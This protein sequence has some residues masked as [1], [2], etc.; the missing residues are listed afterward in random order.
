[1]LPVHMYMNRWKGTMTQELMYQRTLGLLYYRKNVLP[2]ASVCSTSWIVPHSKLL[3]SVL[4]CT[5]TDLPTMDWGPERA[6]WPVE[7]TTLRLT[8]GMSG[9]NFPTRSPASHL[10]TRKLRNSV[11]QI[12]TLSI[13][14]DNNY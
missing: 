11:Q 1:M 13:Y 6:S 10:R 7:S 9:A 2:V 3:P 14:Y 12:T 4:E 8:W 5:T